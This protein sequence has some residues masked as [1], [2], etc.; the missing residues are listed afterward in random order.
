MANQ[1]LNRVFGTDKW[2]DEL[3]RTHRQINLFGEEDTQYVRDDQKAIVDFYLRRLKKIFP[4]V[5]PEPK[6][7]RNSNNAPLFAL[8]FAAA[9]PGPGGRKALEIA[10]YLL[11]YW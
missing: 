2:K 7:F 10:D 6:W 1:K 8:M 3:Y 9:N 4:A 11:T 5:A